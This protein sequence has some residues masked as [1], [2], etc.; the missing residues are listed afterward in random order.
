[1]S[2]AASEQTESSSFQRAFV[3]MSLLLGEARGRSTASVV[4]ESTWNAFAEGDRSARA[5]RI[6]AEVALILSDVRAMALP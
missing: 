3:A 6:A 5:R 2:I 4:P 1:M